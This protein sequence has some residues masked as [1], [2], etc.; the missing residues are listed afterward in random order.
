MLLS[1][2]ILISCVSLSL[3]NGAV[4][5]GQDYPS[6][7]IRITTGPAG[8][9]GD[10]VTRIVGQGISVPLGQPV[11]VDN[12]GS[13]FLAADAVYKQPPDGYTLTLQGAALW[14]FPLLQKVP[15]D[16]VA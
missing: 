4:A 13:G 1:R 9:G 16:A 15:Y 11:I 10:I 14:I 5:L 12:R 8:G 2:V 7:P 6:K 3:L